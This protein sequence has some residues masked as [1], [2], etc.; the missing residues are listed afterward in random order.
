M[1]RRVGIA[2][3]F[4]LALIAPLQANLFLRG[5]GKLT[6][7]PNVF[8]ATTGNDSNPGTQASP[9]LTAGKA[10]IQAQAILRNGG[11]P[12]VTFRGGTYPIASTLNFGSADSGSVSCTVTWKSFAAENAIWSGGVDLTGTFTLCATADAVCN[13]GATGIY[14]SSNTTLSAFRELY[15]NGTHRE[16]SRSTDNVTVTGWTQTSGGY[17]LSSAVP[18]PTSSWKNPTHIEVIIASGQAAS[19]SQPGWQQLRC[20]IGSISG[21]TV[22]MGTPCWTLFNA[23]FTGGG[24]FG[25]ASTPWWIEN[26][27]E[28][29]PACGVTADGQGCWYFD[30]TGAAK[31]DGLPRPYYK[32]APGENIN[33]AT[34]IVPQ[35]TALVSGT[36]AHHLAF[37]RLTFAHMTW[38]PDV[39]GDDY[40]AQYQGYYCTGTQSCGTSCASGQCVNMATTEMPAAVSFDTSSHDITFDHDLFTHNG[41]R[42]LLLQKTSQNISVTASIFTDNGG[43]AIQI[44]EFTDFAQGNAA[45]QTATITVQNNQ[46]DGPFEYLDSGGVLAGYVRSLT[47]DHNTLN[48]NSAAPIVVNAGGDVGTGYSASN[49]A[50]NNWVKA[51]C[52][53]FFDCGD[54]YSGGGA[55]VTTVSGNYLQN[56]SNATMKGAMYPDEGAVNGTWTGNVIDAGSGTLD[57]FVYMWSPTIDNNAI[58]NNFVA[59]T[60]LNAFTTGSGSGNTVTGTTHYT[61]GSPPAGAVTIINNAGIQAGVTPGP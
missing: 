50:T 52:V 21:S 1:W 31:G 16:R 22:T 37:S 47:I 51:P 26:A 29:L 13:G 23:W 11:C 17:T 14:Q 60:T 33:T 45:L 39:S 54:I 44:G 48:Q 56:T 55:N 8:V 59:P 43:G 2:A 20:T 32:P 58:P 6:L 30:Y 24:H 35:A 18:T 10:Q 25:A 5:A 9:F 46:I 41:G 57:G 3:L 38:N 12:T 34:I 53:L 36:G 61:T 15:V 4:T 42:S 19:S 28:L 49:V 40:M 7:D 27:Y